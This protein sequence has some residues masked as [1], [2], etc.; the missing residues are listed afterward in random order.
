M[1]ERSPAGLVL[2]IGFGPGLEQCGEDLRV[3]ALDGE[4][5]RAALCGVGE[6]RV[7]TGLEQENGDG[8]FV[9]QDRLFERRT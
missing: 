4:V 3:V 1:V 7:G 6:A 2:R 8:G 9:A 5:Q